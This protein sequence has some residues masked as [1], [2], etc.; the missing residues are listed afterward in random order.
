MQY[1]WCNQ[2]GF[3]MILYKKLCYTQYSQSQV[4]EKDNFN[5]NSDETTVVHWFGEVE[6][7]RRKPVFGHVVRSQAK[8]EHKTNRKRISKFQ[9][10]PRGVELY[11]AILQAHRS[12]LPWDVRQVGNA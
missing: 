7:H 1:H 4:K 5:P 6:N 12:R 11:R 9:M 2:I 8:T 3:Q 10:A